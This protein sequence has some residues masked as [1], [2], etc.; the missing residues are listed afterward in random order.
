MGGAI[1]LILIFEVCMQ[2]LSDRLRLSSASLIVLS[3]GFQ[4]EICPLEGYK[5]N[6][7]YSLF[8][9]THR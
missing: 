7:V 3:F 5:E 4:L 9:K 6:R 8:A 2:S 1:L